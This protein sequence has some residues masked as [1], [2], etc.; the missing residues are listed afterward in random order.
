M[1]Y[2]EHAQIFSVDISLGVQLIGC[3][4]VLK[5]S[6]SCQTVLLLHWLNVLSWALIP[7]LN[8][9]NTKS[10]PTSFGPCSSAVL[11]QWLWLCFARCFK[12]VDVWD[13]LNSVLVLL[14]EDCHLILS[15]NL[16]WMPQIPI[17]FRYHYE[18]T[19]SPPTFTLFHPW[20]VWYGKPDHKSSISRTYVSVKNESLFLCVLPPS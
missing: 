11:A 12:S 5:C 17:N 8:I 18:E 4:Y 2:S 1:S 3:K 15:L 6:F 19:F 20:G 7:T 10:S 14:G 13:G 16:G 9:T